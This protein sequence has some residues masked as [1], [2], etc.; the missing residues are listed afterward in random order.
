MA[1]RADEGVR[2]DGALLQEVLVARQP[3]FGVDFEVLGYEL[4]YRDAEGAAPT[5]SETS[6]TRATAG[7]LVDGVLALGLDELTGG[8]DAWINVPV[9]LLLSDTILDVPSDGLVLELLEDADVT[10]VARALARH[11]EAGFRLALDGVVPGDARLELIDA[12]DVVKV[13]LLSAGHGPGLQLIRDLATAGHTVL[14]EKVEDPEVFDLA[15]AAG[16]RLLQGFYFARPLTVRGSR[17]LGMSAE[18]LRL[19]HE[20]DRDEVDLREVEFLIRSDVT[21]S[22]RFLRL[23]LAFCRGQPI[24]S[25]HD[26]LVWLGVRAVQRWV[27][28]LVMSATMHDAPRELVALATVR[29]RGCELVEGLRGGSHRLDAF[30]LGMFSVFGHDGLL[31]AATLDGLPVSAEV[32][33]ALQHGRGPYR[34]L[35]EIMLAAEQAD[36]EVVVGHGRSLGV[37]PAPLAQA[38]REALSWGSDVKRAMG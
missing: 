16:A 38:Y 35:L 37:E 18:H 17:P 2:M 14:A 34:Q 27:R 12:V 1:V 5:P 30:S 22:D 31:D 7:V 32:R 10:G 4:L 26:G 36:W 33:E 3:I 11:R 20:L 25:I 23:V 19:L 15:V 9:E 8:E 24:D 28:L 6:G 29:A 21:L 13:D